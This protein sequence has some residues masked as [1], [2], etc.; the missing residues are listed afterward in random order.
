M[1]RVALRVFALAVLLGS[2]PL[3]A[4]TLVGRNGDRISGQLVEQANGRIVFISDA[5]GR[6]EVS[7]D[8]AHVEF[9]GIDPTALP[10]VAEPAQ[11]AQT[12]SVAGPEA[13][14]RWS[15]DVGAKLNLDRGSL[16]TSEDR[17]DTRLT[18]VRRTERGEWHGNLAYKYK[19][20]E[21]EL[22]DNDWLASLAYDRFVSAHR[23][24]AARL[25]LDNE[26]A[27]GGYDATITATLATGWRLW[28]SPKHYLRIGPAVGYLAL[29]RGDDRFNGA[30]LGLYARGM[31]PLWWKATLTGELQ[32]LDSL[33]KGR[34]GG[35]ALRVS[36]PL[37]ER[38]VLSLGW[39]YAWTDLDLES[40]VTSVW[41]WDLA[42]RFGPSATDR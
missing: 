2:G 39:N 5:F 20:T 22:R 37:S 15:M 12:D 24:N 41:R 30:A 19:K 11:T 38:L 40:G 36:R 21:G 42:W 23:F 31:T 8:Q 1:K 17:L 27:D 18:A 10:P 7:S 26:L 3:H 16:K 29:T 32:F 28:E 14:S 6:L 4:D 34:Y 13:P 33:G 25:M 35:A 9:E